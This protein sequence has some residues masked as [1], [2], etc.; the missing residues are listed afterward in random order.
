MDALAELK[1]AIV[2]AGLQPFIYQAQWDD[3]SRRLIGL[4]EFGERVY[5]DLQQSIDQE[6][7]PTTGEKP[8]EFTEEN[9][10]MEAFIEERVQRFVLGSRESVLNELLAH[11]NSTGGNGYVCLTGVPGSGK[12]AL[13]AHLSRHSTLNSQL[14]TLLIC[15]F[16][17]AS[18]GSTDVR[19]TL[20]RLCHE[21]V[22]GA[23]L[24][25]EIPEDPE[26]LR[27]AFAEILKQAAA[28]KHVLIVLDAINQF[29]SST[30][31][32]GLSWL[33]EELPATM[34]IILSAMSESR[35]QKSEISS[36]LESLRHRRI[37]PKE[38]GLKPLT[39][40]DANAIIR[41]FLHRYRKSM[42]DDQRA[43]L[44]AKAD[45]GTPLYL[46]VALEELRTLGTYEE[47]TNRIAQLPPDTRALFI[48]ILKRLEDDDGF[49]DASGRKIGREL[50]PRF[51]SLLGA[52]R[53]GLSQQELV[54]LLSFGDPRGN[55]AALA[56]LLRPYL[57]QRGELLDFYH[58]QFRE[59]VATACLPSESQRLAA[60]EQLATYFRDKADPERN[61]TWKGAS[62]RP[63]LEV[64]FYLVGAQRTDD[65][66]QTLCDL[67]FV[68]TRGRLSQVFELITDY[69]LAQKNLPEAQVDLQE[70]RA[71]EERVRRWMAEIIEY[72]RQRS[73]RRDRLERGE[74]VTEPEPKLPEPVPTCEMWSE[75]R[76]QVECERIIQSPTRR[77]R[78]EAFAG[79]VSGQ[80][81]PLLEHGQR[82][83]FVL[84]QAFNTEPAGAVHDAAK[85]L[86]ATLTEPYLLRRWSP[87]ARPNP[88]P[89]LLRTLEGHSDEVRSVSVTPQGRQA[90]SGSKDQTL[91]VWD[92]E[93]GQCLLTLEGHTDS[94][95]SVSLTPDGRRVF[96]GAGSPTGGIRAHAAPDGRHTFPG[97]K[98]KTI[99][100]WDLESGQCLRIIEGHSFWGESVTATPDGRR[101][102]SWSWDKM[103]RVWNL[104]SGQCLRTL[105]GHNDGV[106]SASV[107]PDGRFAISGSNDG[108]LRVWN[109][110]SGQ[111]VR[112]FGGHSAGVLSV[113]VTPDGR[114][115][116]SGGWDQ[117]LRVWDLASGKCLWTLA[118]HTAAVRCVS[119][120]PDGLIAVTGS[121]DDV[122]RVWDLENG[123]CLR[124]LTGHSAGVMSVSVTPDGR[125]AVSGGSDKTLRLWNLEN[126][127][128]P[129]TLAERI[130]EVR[131]MSVAPEGR[132]AVSCG[133]DS[134]L[135]VWVQESGHYLR[136]LAGHS[137]EVSCVSVMPNGR[138]AV[139]GSWDQ[140]LRVWDLESGHC[141]FTLK[142][143]SGSVSCVG[144][145]PDGRRVVSG[146]WDQTVRV[147]DLASGQCLWLLTGHSN[148][149]SCVSVTPDGRRGISGSLDRTLRVWDL[150]S[151]EYLRTLEGCS[152][153]VLSVSISPDGRIAVSGS[154]DG[155]LQVWDL[156]RGLCLRVLKGHNGEVR[157]LTVT[158]DGRRVISGSW[159]KSL[160][161]WDLENGLCIGVFVTNAPVSAI[162]NS[163]GGVLA[164][165]VKGEVLFLELRRLPLG[166]AIIT[167]S[168]SERVRCPVCGQKFAPPLAVLKA[169]RNTDHAGLLS[170]CPHCQHP[171]QFNSFFA[172]SEDYAEILRRGLKLSRREK[173]AEHEETL[174]HLAALAV[175]LQS[176][177][178]STEAAEFQREH[179]VLVTQLA[180]RKKCKR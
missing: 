48:W 158:S 170:H 79:F 156:E 104:K 26:K 83:G 75:E 16:V 151:G 8:D 50:V 95:S 81:Y 78:L 114:R 113:S 164:T 40:E 130:N 160:R 4:K 63:F 88:K 131:S 71:C 157:S 148:T 53:H 41:E 180:V 120:T 93:N 70:K 139:S 61:Q 45:A 52:S 86:L 166:P 178:K 109:L 105:T 119:I 175:H 142:G 100:V 66:C 92:L 159:D 31:L 67:R 80:C 85:P 97:S 3:Q 5:A 21:L 13:L 90:V 34:R 20:R 99:R 153:G 36:A 176:I 19:R 47:I 51:V 103:L 98:D 14:P 121:G 145:I 22:T 89:A 84:Q 24:T 116:V 72:S 168:N 179:D 108:T 94:V 69:R 76:I 112:I 144:V 126:G 135:K 77:D 110:D 74:A 46:L 101:A 155:A 15:H 55:V 146:S 111:C 150:K 154:E 106:L 171:L 96:S 172:T 165:T 43:A 2:E 33:P 127:R 87:E 174:A 125:R 18:P 27:V 32:A 60:H 12:S 136:T 59:A 58:G 57:M 11:A 37:P 167:S 35:G 169:I 7:G 9:A 62:P 163:A 123:Q 143:H 134:T 65:Y 117:M 38:I 73:D 128:C 161:V 137:D 44:L 122:L 82:P 115:A 133:W 147:W 25:I 56:Q 91:R 10:A 118:G 54:E 132:L 102:V 6:F 17:G 23:G 68:E 49:R 173:G 129:L 1:A 64:V 162:A 28:K 138:H 177:G 42:T 149:V 107:T 140:T 39:A 124:T 152:N 141:L 30:Q 29:D